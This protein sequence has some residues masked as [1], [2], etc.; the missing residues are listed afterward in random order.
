MAV[1][2]LTTTHPDL[3]LYAKS[4]YGLFDANCSAAKSPDS[5]CSPVWRS[6]IP[7]EHAA[8]LEVVAHRSVLFELSVT[9][10]WSTSATLSH[11][12][13]PSREQTKTSPLSMMA[14]NSAG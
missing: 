8:V 4:V 13:A 12:Q 10:K 3:S 9:R 2:E 7:V 6:T 11:R 1:C 14:T 5:N